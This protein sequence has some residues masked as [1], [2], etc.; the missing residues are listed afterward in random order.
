MSR[1]Q[2][3]AVIVGA[4]SLSLTAAL[5]QEFGPGA[6]DLTWNTIDNGGGTSTG[7]GFELAGTIG[8]PDAG[9]TL[10]GGTFEVRGGFW[11]G[12]VEP[13]D[14]CPADIAPPPGD[15][16]VGVP[17]LLAIINAWGSCPGCPED[18]APLTGD[19]MVGV[20]DLLAVINAWGFCN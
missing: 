19:G 1:S 3:S 5:A 15:G 11:A 9:V 18:I 7:G 14:T 16:T 4:L 10:I 12:G 6:F 8:Q 20:P 17:D 13:V 2:I